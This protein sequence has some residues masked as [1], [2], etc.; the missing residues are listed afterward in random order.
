MAKKQFD[1]H[2][3]PFASIRQMVQM[4]AAE[5]GDKA[6]YMFKNKAG[7]VE[8]VTFREFLDVTENLGAALCEKGLGSSHIACI[9][10]N[11]YVWITA[12]V[13]VLKSAGVFVPIDKELPPQDE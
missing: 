10:E 11:S 13:T 9:G 3:K 1:Y 6:A 4:A 7:E 12:F 5:N 8:S 2:V